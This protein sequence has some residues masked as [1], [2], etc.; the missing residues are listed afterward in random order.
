MG[1][2]VCTK[3]RLI[4]DGSTNR[5]KTSYRFQNGLM[6]CFAELDRFGEIH[7]ILP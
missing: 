1:K 6:Y 7:S 5:L 2:K 3:G 4:V